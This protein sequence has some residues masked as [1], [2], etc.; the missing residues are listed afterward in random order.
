VN[1]FVETHVPNN[2][3]MTL[4]IK[5]NTNYKKNTKHKNMKEKKIRYH[6]T[7]LFKVLKTAW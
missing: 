3:E 6:L 2:K 1:Q 4:K 7:R 5:Q